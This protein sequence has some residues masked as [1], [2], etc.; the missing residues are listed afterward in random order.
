MIYYIYK[1]IKKI[2]KFVLRFK[3]FIPGLVWFIIRPF[4]IGRWNKVGAPIPLKSLYYHIY[5]AYLN[6]YKHGG[7]LAVY[8]YNIIVRS[9]IAKLSPLLFMGKTVKEQGLAEADFSKDFVVLHVFKDLLYSIQYTVEVVSYIRAIFSYLYS[10]ALIPILVSSVYTFIKR[11][12]LITIFTS[13]GL[14]SIAYFKHVTITEILY[15]LREHSG[16]YLGLLK[17]KVVNTINYISEKYFSG[18]Y[19][20]EVPRPQ[21]GWDIPSK[22][23]VSKIEY[24][25]AKESRD[26]TIYYII[27]G[28][29]ILGSCIYWYYSSG[30]TPPDGGSL[31]AVQQAVPQGTVG[32]VPNAVWSFNPQD[33]VYNSYKWLKSWFINDNSSSPEGI[34]VGP[35]S[36][37]RFRV[38][39]PDDAIEM[40]YVVQPTPHG[41]PIGEAGMSSSTYS[42]YIKN[43]SDLHLDAQNA[44]ASSSKHV[45]T[46]ESVIAD[47]RETLDKTFNKGT[48]QVEAVKPHGRIIQTVSMDV[49]PDF[50]G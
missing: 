22:L 21:A 37:A 26:Y 2:I 46:Q 29:T 41:A 14:A 15:T 1:V 43:P 33:I 47:M 35:R 49:T 7:L 8:R 16:E 3:Y 40:V 50:K 24:S 44:W 30:S 34:P 5:S 4:I 17:N 13:S 25:H 28:L 38:P 12:S 27:I 23:E 9:E 36:R 39:N 20:I 10:A 18:K 31:H 11:V 32:T 48:S 6:E 19:S 45:K 42:D